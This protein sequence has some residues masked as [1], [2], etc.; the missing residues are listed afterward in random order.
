MLI[1]MAAM[2]SEG[3]GGSEAEYDNNYV[4]GK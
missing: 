2:G 4:F 1:M 3:D